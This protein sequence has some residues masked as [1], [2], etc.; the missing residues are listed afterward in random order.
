[1]KILVVDDD[2]GMRFS[3]KASL[4]TECYAV[5]VESDGNRGLY[6]AKTNDYDLVVLD[7]ILP[8]R[9]GSEICREL[10]EYGKTMPILLISGKSDVD[11]RVLLLND[12]ADDYV[13]KPFSFVEL[14]ARVRALLRRPP[15][16]CD[17]DLRVGDLVLDT[18]RYCARRG[19][20]KIALT[21]KEFSLLEYLM[22]HAGSVVT[23]GMIYEHVWDMSADPCSNA[24]MTHIGNLRRKIDAP[25]WRA[26]IHTIPGRGYIMES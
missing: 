10:R 2:D 14:N 9:H 16:L 26:L 4:E 11:R 20:S 5:D 19:E 21:S 13:T 24:I 6:Q 17:K 7:D 1:M 3:I 12:G 8:G 18:A 15:V 25:G 22:R 23:H